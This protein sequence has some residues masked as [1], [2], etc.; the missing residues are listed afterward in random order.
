MIGDG[1]NGIS[2]GAGKGVSGMVNWTDPTSGS[3]ARSGACGGGSSVGVETHV[4]NELVEVGG[5]RMVTEGDLER[6]SWVDG[7]AERIWK[8]SLRIRL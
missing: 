3:T 1:V 2:A 4:D 6:R 8:H 5:F 7:S